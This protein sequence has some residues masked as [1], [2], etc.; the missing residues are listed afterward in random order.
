MPASR[1][2]DRYNAILLDVCGTLMFDYDRYGPQAD[3]YDTYAQLGGFLLPPERVFEIINQI[4]VTVKEAEK[5]EANFDPFPCLHDFL[6]KA[7]GAADLDTGEQQRLE[8]VFARHECGHISSAVAESVLELYETH[9]LGILSNIW[10]LTSV[11]E[12]ELERAGIRSLF[13]V[14]VWSSDLNCIKPAPRIFET[15]LEY[16]DLPPGQ[17][18]MVGDTFLRDIYGA[19]RLGMGAAWINPQDLPIPP[20]YGVQPDLVIRHIGDLLTA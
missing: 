1:F 11:F 20:E 5:L 15:A 6:L 2:I 9:P 3:Y 7:D 8:L 12:A 19:K 14:R 17:I 18:L 4:F 13:P 10:S 16:F